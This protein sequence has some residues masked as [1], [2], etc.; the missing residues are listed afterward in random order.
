VKTKRL[1]RAVPTPS[2]L[3][4]ASD[5]PS[6]QAPAAPASGPLRSEAA[7]VR[8]GFMRRI[9]SKGFLTEL[10]GALRA[11]PP[12]AQRQVFET[13]AVAGLSAFKVT[14][15]AKLAPAGTE[16][17]DPKLQKLDPHRAAL[18]YTGALSRA[19]LLDGAAQGIDWVKAKLGFAIPAGGLGSEK[20]RLKA[21][22]RLLGGT[23]RFDAFFDPA[24]GAVHLAE[25]T[26]PRSTRIEPADPE[27]S[28]AVLQGLV[29]A[30]SR[31]E[32]LPS[33]RVAAEC[34]PP[35]AVSLLAAANVSLQGIQR[36]DL[37]EADLR[38]GGLTGISASQLLHR[39]INRTDLSHGL[40]AMC[41]SER[42]RPSI[43][44]AFHPD[45]A[46]AG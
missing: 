38:R 41:I 14:A 11:A 40:G 28:L 21:I 19:L 4:K 46:C 29:T 2:S 7:E 26:I 34:L 8:D 13:G 9:A 31:P 25:K 33:I 39:M 18:A 43:A 16:F 20:E 45:G 44:G 3:G 15:R 35:S 23:A 17:D 30:G 27:A 6:A 5:S 42:P 32:L 36:G 1:E 22:A 24:T 37:S 10:T 12:P